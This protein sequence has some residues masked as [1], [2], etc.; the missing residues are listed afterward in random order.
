[1]NRYKRPSASKI[2]QTAILRDVKIPEVHSRTA[3]SARV[4]FATYPWLVVL[5]QDCDL[6][7]DHHARSGTGPPNSNPVSRDKRLRSVLLCPAFLELEILSGT[8]VEGAH[9]VSGTR[10][11]I[12]MDNRDE[13]FHVLNSEP[14]LVEETLI[15]DFKLILTATPEYVEHWI[16]NHR[17]SR[18]A[19]L[20]PPYRDR[21]TQ[22]FAN[23][24]T[25]IAEP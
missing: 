24:F 18:V 15:V 12:L 2:Q 5:N 14:P 3:R 25:R 1:M 9:E 11:H 10:M 8:Y 4:D 6:E 7:M 20:N 13:R 21:L 16:R 22:R 19:I 23:Y 17:E